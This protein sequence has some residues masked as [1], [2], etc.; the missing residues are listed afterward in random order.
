MCP[1]LGLEKMVTVN[2]KE[3]YTYILLKQEVSV[4]DWPWENCKCWICQSWMSGVSR[5]WPWME[6]SLTSGFVNSVYWEIAMGNSLLPVA[7]WARTRYN[8]VVVT[9][10]LWFSKS[11]TFMILTFHRKNFPFLFLDP[12]RECVYIRNN[13]QKQHTVADIHGQ[14]GWYLLYAFSVFL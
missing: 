11:K 7:V 5:P 13:L 6:S 14:A 8:R 9:E 3:I 12:S 1:C 2:Q 10:A 4:P